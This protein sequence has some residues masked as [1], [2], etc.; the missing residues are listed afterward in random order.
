MSKTNPRLIQPTSLSALDT[1]IAVIAHSQ[2][3][4]SHGL[5]MPPPRLPCGFDAADAAVLDWIAA[6]GRRAGRRIVLM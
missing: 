1:L 6:E 5:R 2:I 4:V 3:V